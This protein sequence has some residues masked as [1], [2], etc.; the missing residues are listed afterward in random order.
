LTKWRIPSWKG[1]LLNEARHIA[2]VKATLSAIPVHTAIA[3]CLSLGHLSA[4]ISCARLLSRLA[5]T[6]SQ[7]DAARWHGKQFVG[8][9]SL[10]GLVSLTYV[11]RVSRSELDGHGYARWA[12]T[13]LGHCRTRRSAQWVH[14]L[15][16]PRCRHSVTWRQPYF[17]QTTGSRAPVSAASRRLCL[18]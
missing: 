12:R 13:G 11:A 2:L 18:R 16:Q 1:N 3:L 9:E 15:Q 5:P 14:S 4:L 10:A 6:P 7:V 8:H 17:G